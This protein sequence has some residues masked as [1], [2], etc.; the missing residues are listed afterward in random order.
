[1][2]TTN[3]TFQMITSLESL[4]DSLRLPLMELLLTVVYSTVN[5]TKDLWRPHLEYLHVY[6]NFE[7]QFVLIGGLFAVF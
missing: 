3:M 5:F 4:C 6:S 2:L 1:M 7:Y